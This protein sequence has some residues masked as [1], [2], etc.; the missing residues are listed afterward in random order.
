MSLDLI[1]QAYDL[2]LLQT[3]SRYDLSS[4]E[5]RRNSAKWLAELFVT[6]VTKAIRPAV[7][8]ELG[9]HSAWFSQQ[10]R[11]ALPD[12]AVHALEANHYSVALYSDAAVR[13]GVAYHHLA[14]G[15]EVK[16]CVFKIA[17][18]RDGVPVKPT[19]GSN[20]L[21]AKRLN[22][23]YEDAPVQMVTVDHFAQ[24]HGLTGRPNVMWIDVEGCA[25]EVLTGAERTLTETL[26]LMVEVEDKAF[27]IG[28]KKAGEVKRLLFALGFIPIARDFEFRSQHNMIFARPTVFERNDVRQILA[29]GLA[30]P[31]RESQPPKGG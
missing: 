19:R 8:L 27:W 17:R 31:A 18:T 1:A 6:L 9:A 16:D 15:D 7:V 14:V 26:V 29:S 20:S 22:I 2:A 25:Y 28:Q 24:E 21:R 10:V 3:V 12:A 5:D 11:N 4:Q 23:Q 13:A 30:A